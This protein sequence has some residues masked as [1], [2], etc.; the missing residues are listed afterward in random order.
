[1]TSCRLL[2]SVTGTRKRIRVKRMK[3]TFALL[4]LLLFVPNPVLGQSNH[5]LIPGPDPAPEQ[6][7][8]QPIQISDEFREG[9]IDAFSKIQALQAAELKGTL[10]YKPILHEADLSVSK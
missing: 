7:N 1:M 10:F 5:V 9:T 2:H 3:T 8:K 4:L 6:T